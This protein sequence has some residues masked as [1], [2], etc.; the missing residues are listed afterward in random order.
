[1]LDFK[2]DYIQIYIYPPLT[3]TQKVLSSF[4]TIHWLGGWK[5]IKIVFEMD[6]ICFRLY[7]Y[8]HRMKIDMMTIMI[9]LGEGVEPP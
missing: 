9:C 5:N 4:S 3:L 8:N 2:K 6:F 1:M 7:H